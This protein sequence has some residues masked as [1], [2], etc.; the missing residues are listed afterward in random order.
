MVALTASLL[1]TLTLSDQVCCCTTLGFDL[2]TDVTPED[3]P[4][5]R[6]LNNLGVGLGDRYERTEAIVDLE[7][8]IGVIREA[9][10]ITPED[11]QYRAG[12]LNDLWSST[13]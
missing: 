7:E 3:H 4:R 5:A 12:W 9:V 2:L 1:S 10:D 8:A 6:W 13:F 11:H